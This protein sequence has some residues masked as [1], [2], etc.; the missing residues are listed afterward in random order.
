MA[1]SP[2]W[3]I[4]ALRFGYYGNRPLLCAVDMFGD[5]TF[6]FVHDEQ[7]TA[8]QL[9]CTVPN[10]SDDSAWSIAFTPRQCRRPFLCWSSNAHRCFV[11]TLGDGERRED[12]RYALLSDF[13][14]Q[15]N[16]PMT[17][18]GSR[19]LFLASASIDRRVRIVRLSNGLGGGLRCVTP[20][21]AAM[22]GG[23]WG[24]GVRWFPQWHAVRDE[25]TVEERERQEPREAQQRRRPAGG[26]WA[27]VARGELDVL[28]GLLDRVA[29][30]FLPEEG[31]QLRQAV[32][33]PHRNPLQ[34]AA[35]ILRADF[36]QPEWVDERDEAHGNNR[37]TDD[38]DEEEE[39][40]EEEEEDDDMTDDDDDDE[41]EDEDDDEHHGDDDDEVA[42]DDIEEDSGEIKSA[43]A[44][45]RTAAAT[46]RRFSEPSLSAIRSTARSAGDAALV[47]DEPADVLLYTT[48][49]TLYLLAS[50]LRV[51]HSVHTPTVAPPNARLRQI[52]RLSFL[53]TI[54]PLGLVVVG[55]PGADRVTLFRVV[56]YAEGQWR[57]VWDNCLPVV[58]SGWGI[59]G[60]E[61]SRVADE[62]LGYAGTGVWAL[63][64]LFDNGQLTAF[65]LSSASRTASLLVKDINF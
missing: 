52:D 14:H 42:E 13:P 60:V 4:N 44:V 51:L 1:L 19:G 24:W 45:P 10:A 8:H 38:D 27:A 21:R 63:Y 47:E 33:E 54:P 28:R 20:A 17:D 25:R 7:Q 62:S 11:A 5:F 40:E 41:G 16:V 34:D 55:S 61:V 49:S 23:S 56:R 43:E 37:M 30:G 36:E 3:E 58:G 64:I 59:K 6:F 22:L 53:V 12:D 2:A 35:A 65:Q 32:A 50:D 39:D 9:H 15:H 29:D 26:G 57:L 18:I 46:R 48:R 31:A